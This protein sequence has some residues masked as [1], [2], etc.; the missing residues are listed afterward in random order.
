[1]SGPGDA[2]VEFV[3]AGA[4][5]VGVR[6]VEVP[7]RWL[8]PR[9]AVPAVGAETAESPLISGSAVIAAIVRGED[10]RV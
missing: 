9:P 6:A 8:S 2:A 1:V 4:W 7:R 5:A 3:V 10:A